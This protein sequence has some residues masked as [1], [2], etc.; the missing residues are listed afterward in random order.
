MGMIPHLKEISSGNRVIIL[1][2]IIATAA[3]IIRPVKEEK[4]TEV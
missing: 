1:T 3:A 4:E 2:V